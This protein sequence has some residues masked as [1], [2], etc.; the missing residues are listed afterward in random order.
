MSNYC[1][2]QDIVKPPEKEE[3]GLEKRGRETVV[4]CAGFGSQRG[5]WAWT[6]WSARVP[7]GDIPPANHNLYNVFVFRE[8]LGHT[9]CIAGI[10]IDGYIAHY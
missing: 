4:P 7:N 2:C 9:S 6:H 1:Y 3:S 10:P 8:Q 5:D